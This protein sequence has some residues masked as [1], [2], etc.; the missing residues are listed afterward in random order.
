MRLLILLPLMGT[1][2][3]C[4]ASGPW[5]RTPDVQ[6][7]DEIEAKLRRVPCVGPMSHWERHY[8]YSGKP[9]SLATLVTFGMSSHWF[10]YS[11]V[12]IDYRE[13]GFG[14]FQGGRFLGRGVPPAADDRQYS[15][16]FGHYDIPTHTAFL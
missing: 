14:E 4:G 11:S 8:T 1:L 10:N 15:L 13:A 9:S 3:A 12:D 5:R 6:I 16:V 7:A 2:A